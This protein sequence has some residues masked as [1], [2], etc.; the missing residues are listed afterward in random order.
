M[1]YVQCTEHC[2]LLSREIFLVEEKAFSQEMLT[3]PGGF[4]FL[5]LFAVTVINNH[6]MTLP[7]LMDRLP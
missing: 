2:S 4:V 5:V 1:N 3:L 6:L 7:G